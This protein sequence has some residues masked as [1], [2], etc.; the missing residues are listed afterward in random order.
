MDSNFTKKGNEKWIIEGNQHFWLQKKG[1][2]SFELV[3]SDFEG[4]SYI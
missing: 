3:C 1:Y 2:D 4:K